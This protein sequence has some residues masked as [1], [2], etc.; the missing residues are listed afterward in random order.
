M[1]K[2]KVL[3]RM[4]K[5]PYTKSWECIAF[6]P[7]F[8]ASYGRIQCYTTEGWNEASFDYYRSTR[9]AKPEEYAEMYKYLKNEFENP[10][11][12]DVEKGY[13][14]PME[15]TIIQKISTKL[16]SDLLAM[17]RKVNNR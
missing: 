14:K 12:Y 17:W 9:K 8:D 11:P 1:E 2:T 4:E 6:F 5:N 7:E 15:L 13:D 3:F 16:Y 10:N